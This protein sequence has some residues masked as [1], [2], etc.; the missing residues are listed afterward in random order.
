VLLPCNPDDPSQR[1]FVRP[2]VRGRAKIILG[3]DKP[4]KSRSTF[5][6]L[7]LGGIGFYRFQLASDISFCLGMSI[8]AA[9]LSI[10]VTRCSNTGTSSSHD[11]VAIFFGLWFSC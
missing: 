1:F 10:G 5:S 8:N 9:P 6:L 7:D 4:L 3:V 2:F 11:K